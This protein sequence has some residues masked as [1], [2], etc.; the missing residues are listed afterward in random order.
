MKKLTTQCLLWYTK[1]L[2]AALAMLGVVSCGTK[3]SALKMVNPVTDIEQYETVGGDSL[4][5]REMR[6]MYGAP[7]ARLKKTELRVMYGP[8]PVMKRANPVEQDG[9]DNEVKQK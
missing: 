5:M 4:K 3:R 2:S 7:P 1:L 9:V 8:P 6:L